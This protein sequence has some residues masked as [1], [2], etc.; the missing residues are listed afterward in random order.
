MRPVVQALT[1]CSPAKLRAALPGIKDVNQRFCWKENDIIFAECSLLT[2]TAVLNRSSTK[3]K[4]VTDCMHVLLDFGAEFDKEGYWVDDVEV[5]T[6]LRHYLPEVYGYA[7]EIALREDNPRILRAFWMHGGIKMES[8]LVVIFEAR[9]V[10]CL[11]A[12]LEAG[13]D[14][15]IVFVSDHVLVTPLVLCT[16]I[17][18]DSTDPCMKEKKM[19]MV[20]M[21]HTLIS[22][23]AKMDFT[24]EGA[25]VGYDVRGNSVTGAELYE[26]TKS[27]GDLYTPLQYALIHQ[28]PKLVK[29][30]VRAGANVDA[31]TGEKSL[32]DFCVDC[33]NLNKNIRACIR[34]VLKF[35][36]FSYLPREVR[37]SF[38][39]L[40]LCL[41]R[42]DI[43]L[44]QDVLLVLI[45]YA[46]I[47][48]WTPDKEWLR[49]KEQQ[50]DQ[51]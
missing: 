50:L 46:N 9:A 38:R 8:S 18:V 34:P 10:H 47:S 42:S 26:K 51:L 36:E 17:R 2:F 41:Q 43:Y 27:L 25:I 11:K 29:T 37:V 31:V 20:E 48:Y 44:V 16:S 3:R 6:G 23:G 30:L 13:G 12:Y 33:G 1:D 5:D 45:N 14:P 15:N 40:L 28:E 22:H 4:Q 24:G 39:I 7:A 32:R 35:S 19:K 49:Q 21:M